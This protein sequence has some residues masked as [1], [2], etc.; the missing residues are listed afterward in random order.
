MS[1]WDRV[2]KKK[3]LFA[4]TLCWIMWIVMTISL[5]TGHLALGIFLGSLTT[6]MII[7]VG[8]LY[9]DRYEYRE[10]PENKDS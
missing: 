7:L 1:G 10:H 8:V 5:F 2:Y 9:P 6:G 3:F 4:T